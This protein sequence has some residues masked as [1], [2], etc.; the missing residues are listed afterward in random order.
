MVTLSAEIM[1]RIFKYKED[2]NTEEE[3]AW[4]V[5]TLFFFPE[6]N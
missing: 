4:N 1:T 3:L 5:K 6:L 2:K